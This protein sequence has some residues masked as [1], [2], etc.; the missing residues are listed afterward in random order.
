ML[1]LTQIRH[2]WPEKFAL[3]IDRP[4]GHHDYTFLH[5]ISSVELHHQ[6][7]V[8]L[9][10]PHT[11]LLYAPGTPQFYCHATLIFHDWFHF[12]AD[13]EAMHSLG[14]PLDTP[15]HLSNSDFVTPIVKEMEAEFASQKPKYEELVALKA[16][17]LFLK[18][19]RAYMGDSNTT[20]SS[21]T[22]R[23]FN[24]LRSE[25]FSHLDRSWSVPVMA[26]K[27]GLSP[28]RFYDI[29][30]SLYANSP[31]SDLI[32]ARID[33]AKNALTF[34]EQSIPEIADSLGYSNLTHFMRQFR[35]HVG[36]TP[37]TYRTQSRLGYHG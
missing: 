26:S 8:I 34:S 29:Y 2:A 7:K 5:F 10:P 14:F 19:S 6:G 9:T 33:T 18:L 37:G 27:V 1:K 30:R 20:V 13:D 36:M 3:V 28:S 23:R 22:E 35:S 4:Q 24:R 25:M 12:C 16:K 31:M 11:C 17:E 32:A 15:F 21:D